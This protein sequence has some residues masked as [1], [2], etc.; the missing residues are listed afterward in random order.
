[1]TFG[2]FFL[3]AWLLTSTSFVVRFF[4][5]DFLYAI[6]FIEL[7]ARRWLCVYRVIVHSM[8]A[9]SMP[10]DLLLFICFLLRFCLSLMTFYF[11][12]SKLLL[13]MLVRHTLISIQCWFHF[14][15]APFK[16]IGFLI[17]R[18]KPGLQ[19]TTATETKQKIC[20]ERRRRGMRKAAQIDRVHD[21]KA[22]EIVRH[23]IIQLFDIF[24][25][26][27]TTAG[28]RSLKIAFFLFVWVRL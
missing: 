21:I 11:I 24:V 10:A 17:M 20:E 7:Y 13:R 12:K 6:W 8:M 1:M 9:I 15:F 16:R 26:S 5:F 18:Q 14:H 19:P 25:A 27:Y 23:N 4:P 2:F 22:N 28:L 3:H